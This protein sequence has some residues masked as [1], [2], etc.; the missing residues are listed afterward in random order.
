MKKAFFL[1]L[2][3]ALLIITTVTAGIQ[4][5]TGSQTVNAAADGTGGVWNT[6]VTSYLNG[7]GYTGVTI[8]SVDALG[9]RYCTSTNH[10]GYSTT[11]YVFNGM[12]TGHE[13]FP[14]AR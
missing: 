7:Y 6:Q 4:S 8:N 5:Y 2:L 11:V 13:D 1:R 10:V 14:T 9:N 3:A 12:I